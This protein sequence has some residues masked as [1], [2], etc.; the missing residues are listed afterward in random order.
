MRE[1]RPIPALLTLES[2]DLKCAADAARDP[3]AWKLETI[4]CQ[5][6]LAECASS[7]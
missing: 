1:D 2:N 4:V 6:L 3:T 7:T 5:A